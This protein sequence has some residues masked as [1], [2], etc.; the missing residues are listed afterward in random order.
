[1]NKKQGEALKKYVDELKIKFDELIKEGYY[2]E[3]MKVLQEAVNVLP[4]FDKKV[5]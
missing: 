5:K 4:R 2:V 3:A 1:M